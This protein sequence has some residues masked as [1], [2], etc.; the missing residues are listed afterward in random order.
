MRFVWIGLS[1]EERIDVNIFQNS[2]EWKDA[3]TIFSFRWK[4]FLTC[5]YFASFFSVLFYHDAE[6]LYSRHFSLFFFAGK[7]IHGLE[8]R[9]SCRLFVQSLFTHVDVCH[10]TLFHCPLIDQSP[11]CILLR[12]CCQNANRSYFCDLVEK[13]EKNFFLRPTH[14]VRLWLHFVDWKVAF[15]DIIDVRTC[16]RQL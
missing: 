14:H 16:L 13:L 8:S 9:A 15:C 7:T 5:D 4:T 12:C 1:P 11:R 10:S 3:T 2:R 6:R